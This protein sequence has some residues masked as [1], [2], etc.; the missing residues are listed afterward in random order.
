MTRQAETDLVVTNFLASDKDRWRELWL[1]YLTFYHTT[2][3]ETT[4]ASTWQR[5]L[6]H[7]GSLRG[8]G[9]RRG[10]AGELVGIAH[11]LPHESAWNTKPACY[12]QDLFVA[13]SVRGQGV[14][15]LLIEA[16]ADKA[17]S[18]GYYNLYWLTQETNKPARL[19]YDNL[20]KFEGFVCYEFDYDKQQK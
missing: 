19:L 6:D 13:P 9:A 16:V 15:R 18:L 14:G 10:K 2:L 4:I 11:F 1:A 17:R 3:P 7:G 8:L 5:V 20:A 12:L